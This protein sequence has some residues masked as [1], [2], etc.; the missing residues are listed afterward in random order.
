MKRFSSKMVCAWTTKTKWIRKSSCD[1]RAE[2][3]YFCARC[4]QFQSRLSFFPTEF[5]YFSFSIHVAI[6]TD[7]ILRV[8][9]LF[10]V[11]KYEQIKLRRERKSVEFLL[12]ASSRPQNNR[13]TKKKWSEFWHKRDER[14]SHINDNVYRRQPK[15]LYLVRFTIELAN[16]EL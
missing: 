10:Y 16:S 7:V 9:I 6:D 12:H 2:I 15:V 8:F 13:R 1:S 14:L 3:E 4:N 11:V 5:K